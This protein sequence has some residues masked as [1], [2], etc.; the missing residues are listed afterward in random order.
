MEQGREEQLL[1]KFRDFASGFY[2]DCTR[3]GLLDAV[4]TIC[5]NTNKGKNYD[6]FASAIANILFKKVYI[7]GECWKPKMIEGLIDIVLEILDYKEVK[8]S[9]T[10]AS[11]M[12]GEEKHNEGDILDRIVE[13][14][15]KNIR[16]SGF[17]ELES[18][19]IGSKSK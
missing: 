8:V 12:L 4:R 11:A 9:F 14:F 2:F 6:R 19:T 10:P 13:Q 7:D 5:I 17:E 3:D 18:Y 1:K 15:N 16:D